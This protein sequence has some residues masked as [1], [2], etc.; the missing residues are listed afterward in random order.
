MDALLAD[1]HIASF[2]SCYATVNGKTAQIGSQTYVAQYTMTSVARQ[3]MA[4]P[5][6]LSQDG[7]SFTVTWERDS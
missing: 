5:S 2:S 7:T 4:R 3:T 6:A 1:F